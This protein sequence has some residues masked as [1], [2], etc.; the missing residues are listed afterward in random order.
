METTL[1]KMNSHNVCRVIELNNNSIINQRLGELGLHKGA[2]VKIIKNSSGQMIIC[3][4]GSKIAL[5]KGIASKII[6]K[7]L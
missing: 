6:V 1:D 5:C 3:S 7:M 4:H 2:K